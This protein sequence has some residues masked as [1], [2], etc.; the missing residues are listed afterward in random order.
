MLA[1]VELVVDRET[2]QTSNELGARVTWRCLELGLH[3]NI[4]QPPAWA[5]S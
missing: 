2:K 3:T 5:E 4:V 1:G